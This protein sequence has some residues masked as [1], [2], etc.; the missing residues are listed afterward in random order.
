MIGDLIFHTAML[1]PELGTMA[2]DAAVNTLE[3][4]ID[5]ASKKIVTN[6]IKEVESRLKLNSNSILSFANKGVDS[7]Y[8]NLGDNLEKS[9]KDV[10]TQHLDSN[11]YTLV[12]KTELEYLRTIAN[13]LAKGENPESTLE[14]LKKHL[15]E[16]NG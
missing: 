11:N 13:T 10:L 3:S 7:L 1:A 14:E 5:N 9:V 2:K 8:K 12:H 16:R 15:N 4:A 6:V